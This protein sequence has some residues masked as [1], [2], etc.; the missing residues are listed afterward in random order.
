MITAMVIWSS[1]VL[2][3]LFYST[4]PSFPS[5]KH[6]YSVISWYFPSLWSKK[7]NLSWT[8]LFNYFVL[9]M[10]ILWLD[11]GQYCMCKYKM[12][13][14]CLSDFPHLTHSRRTVVNTQKLCC[15][16]CTVVWEEH[17]ANQKQ[18][19]EKAACNFFFFYAFFFAPSLL[20]THTGTHSV[21]RC[22]PLSHQLP[23]SHSY[24]T[25]VRSFLFGGCC[26]CLAGRGSFHL[27]SLCAAG[28][29][30]FLLLC[31]N[32]KWYSVTV[33]EHE[34]QCRVTHHNRMRT[35]S[36]ILVVDSSKQGLEVTNLQKPQTH[37][38][39]KCFIKAQIMTWRLIVDKEE[40]KHFWT[41]TLFLD[42]CRSVC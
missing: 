22:L 18:N 37:N 19:S 24:Q 34:Q 25:W 39:Y 14:T 6:L 2:S 40:L 8:H 33:W 17:Y 13:H 11:P 9:L 41:W 7:K 16:C 15:S 20:D 12:N 5:L 38:A 31:E 30:C 36:F 23:Q 27:C 4:L 21:H 10:H 3:E 26:M 29:S 42:P 35:N 32:I 28:L 1:V